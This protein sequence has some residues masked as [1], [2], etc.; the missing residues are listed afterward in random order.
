[1]QEMSLIEHLRELR[2]AIVKSAW[3]IV[4]GMIVLYNFTE[5]LFNFIRAPI[6]PYLPTSGL[7][8]TA[9]MDK[10]M[11]HIKLAIFGGIILSCPWWLYQV[12]KFISPALYS[13]EKKYALAFISVGATLFVSGVA[14]TYYLVLPSSFEFLLGFGGNVDKPMITIDH[15]LSFVV[16]MCVVFGVVFEIPLVL[17]LL[18]AAGIVTADL[19]RKKRRI[20]IIILAFLAAILTPTPD[21]FSMLIMLVPMVA[22]YEISIVIIAITEKRRKTSAV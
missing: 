5:P 16:T 20:A 1:V 8:F 22:F 13:K 17:V 14:F 3:G 18:G 10:F 6:A 2:K 4:L 7:V 21:A 12:W 19:L 9:P 15:Y 11:A